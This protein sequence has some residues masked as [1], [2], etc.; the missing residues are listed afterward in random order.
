MHSQLQFPLLKR[1]LLP[2]LLFFFLLPTA[3]AKPWTYWARYTGPAEKKRPT[4]IAE[5][6]KIENLDSILLNQI[7]T[8]TQGLALDVISALGK[9]HL[10]PQLMNKITADDSGFLALTL[11]AL[12]TKDNYKSI[13]VQ[14]KNLIENKHEILSAANVVALIEPMGRMGRALNMATLKTLVRHQYPEVRSAVL[15]YARTILLE[16]NRSGYYPLFQMAK[17]DRTWQIRKQIQMHLQEI[18]NNEVLARKVPSPLLFEI[19]AEPPRFKIDGRDMRVIFGYKD[20]R[21]GRFVG[22]LHE[23]LAFVQT[24]L[25][26]CPSAADSGPCGFQRH[27]K[28]QELFLK[29]VFKDDGED[30]KV[31]LRV[32]HSSVATDDDANRKNLFQKFQ[33]DRAESLFLQGLAEADMVFYNG[34]SRFGGGPDFAPPQ[35]NTSGFVDSEFY[36]SQTTGTNKM[37]TVLEKRKITPDTQP[38]STFGIFSC[39]SSQHFMKSIKDTGVKTVLTSRRLLHYSEALRD[40]VKALGLYLHNI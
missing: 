35:L 13:L 27:P 18:R 1:W 25:A 24:L 31:L 6:K 11:N 39:T 37:L 28:D 21:P 36:S 20:A 4:A 19:D 5:L 12:L 3:H 33:S 38:L 26:P 22:D 29:R 15:N 34:H 17:S 32:V 30:V 16:H 40:S 7:G 2:G 14:Y 23:R 8:D 10:I 9:T